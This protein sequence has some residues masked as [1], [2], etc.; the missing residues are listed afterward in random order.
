MTRSLMILAMLAWGQSAA[1]QM[2]EVKQ[3]V[4]PPAGGNRGIRP[5]PSP[6]DGVFLEAG[7]GAGFMLD[8]PDRELRD[9][10]DRSAGDRVS[11]AGVV[12]EPARGRAPL[13]LRVMHFRPFQ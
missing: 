2:R 7:A 1:A 11:L 6:G 9:A 5:S 4:Y 3:T 8:V 13:R 12:P 10:L